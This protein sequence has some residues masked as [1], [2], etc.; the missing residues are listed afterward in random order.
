M[1]EDKSQ[2]ENN[3]CTDSFDVYSLERLSTSRS[4]LA[5]IHRSRNGYNADENRD[6]RL[7]ITLDNYNAKN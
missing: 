2:K 1:I 6:K 4:S 3:N 5:K 7:K